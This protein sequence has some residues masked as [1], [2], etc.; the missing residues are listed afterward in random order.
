MSLPGQNWQWRDLLLAI[1]MNSQKFII[2]VIFLNC[3]NHNYVS[4]FL[5]TNY[6]WYLLPITVHDL[7]KFLNLML[8]NL[9]LHLM[10]F[11][12]LFQ[13]ILQF[14][15]LIQSIVVNFLEVFIFDFK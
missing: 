14:L 6:V 5:I 15:K 10:N 9:F 8:I 2:I 11:F 7:F 1:R 3:W 4:I 13:F 12:L